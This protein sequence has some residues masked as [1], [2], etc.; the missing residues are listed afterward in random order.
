MI[1]SSKHTSLLIE[2]KQLLNEKKFFAEAKRRLGLLR[3]MGLLDGPVQVSLHEVQKWLE[4]RDNDPVCAQLD[5]FA[6]QKLL[7]SDR[8]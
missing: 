7:R 4:D 3:V 1:S 6:G 2:E 5:A 8:I